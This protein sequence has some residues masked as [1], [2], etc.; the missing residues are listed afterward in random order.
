[1]MLN[2]KENNKALETLNNKIL[3]KMND[4][5][6]IASFLMSPLSKITN[7]G[8]T[9]QFKLVKDS[10]SNRFNGLLIHNTIPVTL[11]VNLTTVRDTGKIFVLKG[12]LLK[13]ITKK[14]YNVDLA[15][16]WVKRLLYDF[17]KEM[18]FPV[19]PKVNKST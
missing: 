14:N 10:N 2:C 1:M 6:L 19:K 7:P 4:R 9:T 13:M 18:Y 16:L 3:G 11:Y 15:S 8:N 5:C 17:A 12:E